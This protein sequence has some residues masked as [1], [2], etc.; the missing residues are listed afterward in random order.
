MKIK[1]LSK[2]PKILITTTAAETVYSFFKEQIPYLLRQGYSIE[3]AAGEGTWIKIHDVRKRFDVP[4]HTIPFVRGINPFSD[5]RAIVLLYFLLR[6][7]KPEILHTS[8]A[9][10]SVISLIAAWLAGVPVRIYLLRGI[11]IF[12]QRGT[13]WFFYSIVQKLQCHLSHHVLC[14]SKSNKNFFLEH[15]L[16]CAD[17][18]SILNNGSSH[19][20]DANDM[21]NPEKADQSV[22]TGMQLK[23]SI[24]KND[25]VFGFIGRFVNEKGIEDLVNAWLTFIK[26]H[27]QTHLFIVGHRETRDS[28]SKD[29]FTKMIGEPSIHVVDNI[30]DPYYYYCL[31]DIFVFPSYREGLP[32]SVLEASAMTIPVITTDALGCVDSVKNNETGFIIPVQ[33]ESELL[34]KMDLLYND[35][36]LRSRLGNNARK[37]VLNFFDP[38]AL[39]DK[40][41]RFLRKQCSIRGVALKPRIAIVTTVPTSLFHFFSNQIAPIQNSGFDVFFISSQGNEWINSKTV[42]EKYGIKVLSVP[43]KNAFLSLFSD[44]KSIISLILLFRRLHLDVLYYCTPKAGILTSISGYIT[45]VPFRIYSISGVFYFGKRDIIAKTTLILERIT[46]WLSHK[47]TVLS[48]SN[49]RYL[50][51]KQVCPEHKMGILSKGSIQGVDSNVLFNREKIDPKNI[52]ALKRELNI[53]ETA[54]IFGFIGRLVKEK[55]VVELIKAWN[56]LKT[57]SAYSVL[58]IIGPRKGA[59]GS[60]AETIYSEIEN[61]P[62][63]KLI[64]HHI[65][66][67]SLYYA[68]MDVFLLPSYREGFP[69][70]VLEAAAMELPVITTDSI[71]CI[72]SV[73]EG[74]TGFCVPVKNVGKLKEKM[75]VLLHEPQLRREMGK[76]ARKRVIN[77][78][79]CD[80]VT[81]ELIYLI[82]NRDFINNQN[83]NGSVPNN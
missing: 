67:L 19:G 41:G 7:E 17:K 54:V 39:S 48:Q 43:F 29:I 27:K 74:V 46:C 34:L 12:Q 15:R 14:V 10:A 83:R 40:L 81:K 58:I 72:D 28:I 62:T 63:I 64:D 18:L 78:F 32:N 69:S 36:E 5:I 53:P 73:V 16:C 22:I 55:G 49:Y 13:R 80:S 24:E 2:R 33:N 38:N 21:F 8:T 75:S 35:G 51:E 44:L 71:G 50:L 66:D 6:R 56:E 59:H 25:I 30:I 70:V 82:K 23:Y 57:D 61:D 9:K 60:L 1:P 20:V 37:F 77:D 3:I 4:V 42:E 52:L 47:V 68:C 76:N 26:E 79:D 31:F 45:R 65:E 11:T